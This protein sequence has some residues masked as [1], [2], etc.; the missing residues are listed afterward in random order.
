M[1]AYRSTATFFRCDLPNFDYDPSVAYDVVVYNDAGNATLSGLI[2]YTSAPTLI[3]IDACIDRGVGYP[4]WLGIRCPAG[5]TITLRGSRFPSADAVAVQFVTAYT[6]A[7][8]T[9]ILLGATLLNSS[10]I[11]AT[12]P[13]LDDAAA[14]EVYGEYGSVEAVFTTSGLNTTVALMTR[15]YLPLNT[16]SITSVS[17]S[18]C[19]SVSAL[20]LTNCR[21]LAVITVVGSNLAVDE[22]LWLDVYQ[23]DMPQGQN[24][25]LSQCAN[26]YRPG[27]EAS[28][29]TW[30]DSLSN[31]TLVFT[32]AYF[33]ADTNVQLQP[34]V[35]YT[36]YTESY[37][38]NFYQV[39]NAFR[40][41]MTYAAVVPTPSSSSSSLS[42]G[43]IAGIVIAA[44]AAA[45]LL[46]LPL[47][48]M[49]RRFDGLSS[50]SSESAR[51]G[52]RRS[53]R[54]AG[55]T[56]SDEYKDVELD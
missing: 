42:S 33:D 17:S 30:Y 43:A 4:E 6:S 20:H 55:G 29:D 52:W 36:V 3:G 47:V 27:T 14:A 51:E 15:L 23:D 19:D 13:A 46:V 44:V 22:S 54:H 1:G 11:T 21:A 9:V 40:L 10:T 48:W 35:V 32:L 56:S 38:S 50:W 2:Q 53:T 7:L 45:V 34:D 28:N 18:S 41:S 49:L 16:P 31:T 24:F 8:V 25:L 37:N 5:T 26:C 12:L 39:S